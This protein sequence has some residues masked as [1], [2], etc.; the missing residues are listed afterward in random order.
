[1]IV[2]L[3]T[4]EYFPPS[5]TDFSISSTFSSIES[6]SF[7]AITKK[8]A[9]FTLSLVSANSAAG[10]WLYRFGL[11]HSISWST[12]TS[13][14]LVS[15]AV[16]LPSNPQNSFWLEAKNLMSSVSSLPNG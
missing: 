15:P 14:S 3:K 12:K 16:P 9:C 7:L 13:V 11:K 2:M 10:L 8:L 1:M 4:A 5:C 6:L